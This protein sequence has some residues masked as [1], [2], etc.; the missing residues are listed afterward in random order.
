MLSSEH[1]NHGESRKK[2]RMV[3]QH[4]E[5]VINL[6]HV[7]Y[8]VRFRAAVLLSSPSSPLA[9]L[10]RAPLLSAPPSRH[11]DSRSV[12]QFAENTAGALGAFRPSFRAHMPLA[13]FSTILG[14]AVMI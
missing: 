7:L 3:I 6:G 4:E 10:L 5:S 9:P 13:L 14:R 12:M 8:G 2:E 1:H 11:G